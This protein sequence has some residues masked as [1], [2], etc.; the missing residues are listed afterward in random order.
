MSIRGDSESSNS[1]SNKAIRPDLEDQSIGPSKPSEEHT[2]PNEPD[3]DFGQAEDDEELIQVW[4]NAKSEET[5]RAYQSDI[6]Q[7]I[8]YVEKPI[9]AVLLQDIL[10]YRKY[11]DAQ[12]FSTNTIIRKIATV[13]SLFSFAAR[14]RYVSFNVGQ[15]VSTPTPRN[16]TSEELLSVGE[17]HRIIGAARSTNYPLRNEAILRLFYA[18]AI[19]RSEMEGLEWRELDS[20]PKLNP[21]RGQVTVFGK[22]NKERTVLVT[23]KTWECLTELRFRE[24]QVGRGEPEDPVFRSRKG[25]PLSAS[26]AYRI[27]RKAAN[28]AGIE[29]KSVSPHSFRHAHITHALQNGAPVHLVMRT[30]GHSNLRVTSR[31]VHARRDESSSDFIED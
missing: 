27:V 20:R 1:K 16:R 29:E 21:P 5:R 24:E 26:Q 4:L 30:V 11:L 17:V 31:Y 8:G 6:D 13:K 12:D 7:F 23:K 3:E 19:R 25:G 18:A 14:I 15:V 28:E 9:Q 10:E 22:G 2:L